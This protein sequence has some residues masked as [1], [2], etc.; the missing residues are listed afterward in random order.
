M[1]KVQVTLAAMVVALGVVTHAQSRPASSWLDRPLS[2]WNRPGA[3]VPGAAID[4]GRRDEII[5]RCDLK[6]P[7]STPAERALGTA[8]WLPFLNFDQRL[9]QGDIEIVDGMIAADGMCRPLGYNI[10]VFIGGRFA[11]TLAPAAMNAREDS[12]SG[13]VRIL[14]AD[15]LSA[16]FVRYTQNDPLCCPSSRLT[17]RYRIDRTGPVVVPVEVRTTR[18]L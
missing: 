8:G 1:R 15:S 3:A 12:S 5:G 14:G 7:A 11:G 18:G 4:K 2:N 16:E 9:V 6:P 13:A 10:F 17:V